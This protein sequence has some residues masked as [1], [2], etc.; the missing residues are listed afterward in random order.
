MVSFMPLQ[1]YTHEKGPW[2]TFDRTPKPVWTITI[3]ENSLS[4]RD[5]NFDPFVIQPVNSCYTDYT[6]VVLVK[7]KIVMKTPR[8]PRT[9]MDSLDKR[10][11]QQNMD[12]R[13]GT[14]NIRSLYRTGTLPS[15]SKELSKYKT[16]LVGVQEV[17]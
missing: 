2:Y 11:K 8:E 9:W 16:D 4:Y 15:I 1:L 17:R 14:C 13:F 7:N 6:T 3:S 10:P 5:L 12:M